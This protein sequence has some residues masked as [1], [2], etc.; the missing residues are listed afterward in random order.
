ML[1][2]LLTKREREREDGKGEGEMRESKKKNFIH[3]SIGR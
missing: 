3:N 1:N 2:Y